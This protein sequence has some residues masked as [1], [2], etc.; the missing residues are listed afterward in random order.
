MVAN[1]ETMSVSPA[2]ER[3]QRP[4]LEVFSG[5]VSTVLGGVYCLSRVGFESHFGAV[6][7]AVTV[8]YFV[9]CFPFLLVRLTR[10]G[11]ARG[12]TLARIPSAVLML[13]AL[14]LLTA[15]GWSGL[16]R[17]WEVRLLLCAVGA[18]SFVYCLALWFSTGPRRTNVRFVAFGAILALWVG[19]L[20]WGVGY[21]SPLFVEDLLRGEA[22]KDT[23][24][25]SS[26]LH[27]IQTYGVPS[28]G[29]DGVPYLAYHYGSHWV[30]AQLAAIVDV[31]AVV[32][33]QLGYPTL[34][35]AFLLASWL[36]LAIR[37]WERA[38]WRE[39]TADVSMD[40]WFL[41][42]AGTILVGFLPPAA[43]T[44][45]PLWDGFLMSESY[46]TGMAV[47]LAAATLIVPRL[48]VERD[49]LPS[50]GCLTDPDNYGYAIYDL[51]AP[52]RADGDRGRC[53]RTLDL[54]LDGWYTL[55]QTPDGA[56]ELVEHTCR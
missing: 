16:G 43:R 55:A 41:A 51:D 48:L 40:G 2:T 21:L 46:A 34:I 35:V 8:A 19:G 20:V 37:L 52:A 4:L 22:N 14:G 56:L 30:F 49:G 10:R 39:P 47:L 17:L 11:A 28:T 12:G 23:L 32:F 38:P 29:I 44:G 5:V 1:A 15:V 7:R 13:V 25:H 18:V 50:A 9:S 33:Y 24:F 45:L 6:V 3:E 36:G 26:I 42:C 54:G 27:M 53:S 31:D